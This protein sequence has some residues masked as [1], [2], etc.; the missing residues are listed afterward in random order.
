[1]R[2]ARERELCTTK[3]HENRRAVGMLLILLVAD[4]K[5]SVKGCSHR[6][7]EGKTTMTSAKAFVERAGKISEKISNGQI[8]IRD[9]QMAAFVQPDRAVE[10]SK[11]RLSSRP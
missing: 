7:G 3:L 6:G 4:K 5:M 10:I 2:K 9:I 8:E 11:F 1:M